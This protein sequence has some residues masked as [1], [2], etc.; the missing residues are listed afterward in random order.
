MI[1]NVTHLQM[2]AK[3]MLSAM[4]NALK[5]ILTIVS[6]TQ[7]LILPEKVALIYLILMNAHICMTLSMA[8]LKPNSRN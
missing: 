4:I 7:R 8:Q 2:N 3:I 6:L 1:S 5:M